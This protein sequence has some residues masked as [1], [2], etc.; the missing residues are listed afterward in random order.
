VET[1]FNLLSHYKVRR[2]KKKRGGEGT[3][4]SFSVQGSVAQG[5]EKKKK[6]KKK[7][8][9]KK[10]REG[11]LFRLPYRGSYFWSL[12]KGRDPRRGRRREEK[13]GGGKC[14]FLILI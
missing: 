6:P 2:G 4:L 7:G 5:M 10:E 12:V 3:G 9:K 11:V 8:G 13:G 1:R 14:S